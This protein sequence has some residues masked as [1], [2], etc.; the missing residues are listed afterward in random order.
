MQ[1][2]ALVV[3]VDAYSAPGIL[4]NAKEKFRPGLEPVMEFKERALA[5]GLGHSHEPTVLIRVFHALALG[6]RDRSQKP[7]RVLVTTP[8]PTLG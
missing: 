6:I 8:R 4:D 1:P 7:P 2:L 5:S 3:A